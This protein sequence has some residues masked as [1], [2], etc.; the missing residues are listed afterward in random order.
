MKMNAQAAGKLGIGVLLVACL[1]VSRL[2]LADWASAPERHAASLAELDEKKV[3]VMELTAAT[4]AASVAISAVPGDA[5]TPIAN[6]ISELGSYLLLVVGAILL[7]KVLL[8]LTGYL[9]F[10]WLVPGACLLGLGSLI[11]SQAWM[12]Q[13][14]WK[15]ALFAAAICLVI[16]VS[17]R[18]GGLVE[19]TLELQQTVNAAARAADAMEEETDGAEEESGGWLSQIGDAITGGVTDLV[20]RAEDTLSRFVDAIAALLIVNCVIPL[21]ILWFF[22]WLLKAI[23]GLK[24]EVPAGRLRQA[25]RDHARRPDIPQG[26]GEDPGSAP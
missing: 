20:Q 15:V 21:L 8:T 22:L 6:Q 13:L 19:D 26:G 23:L 2:F 5:T 7:E 3:T 9:S 12:R 11:F 10:A 14:A 17:L 4:A 24:L 16:P 1:L 18:V 25:A